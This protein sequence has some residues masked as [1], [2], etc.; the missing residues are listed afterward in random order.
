MTYLYITSTFSAIVS[1]YL[2]ILHFYG[3]EKKKVDRHDELLRG[4]QTDL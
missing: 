1:I 3:R 4:S 2:L